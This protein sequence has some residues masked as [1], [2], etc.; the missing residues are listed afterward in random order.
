[1]CLKELTLIKPMNHG[2]VLFTIIITFYILPK[3]LYFIEKRNK[4]RKNHIC[5]VYSIIQEYLQKKNRH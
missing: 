5:Y 3:K 4:F 1:M 2:N